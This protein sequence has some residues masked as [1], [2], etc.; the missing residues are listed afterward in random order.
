MV[1]DVIRSRQEGPGLG[2]DWPWLEI[3]Q[4]WCQGVG[5]D[6]SGDGGG[7]GRKSGFGEDAK[8]NWDVVSQGT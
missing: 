1:S 8:P 3:R 7:L 2:T 4:G 5:P 6:D